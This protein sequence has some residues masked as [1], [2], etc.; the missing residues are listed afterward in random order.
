MSENFSVVSILL[1][2]KAWMNVF[3]R[4]MIVQ[5]HHSEHVLT[6]VAAIFVLVTQDT[7]EMVGFVLVSF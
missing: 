1:S 3:K 7:L 4:R 6:Q 2:T 5:M